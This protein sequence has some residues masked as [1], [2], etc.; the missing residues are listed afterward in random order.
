MNSRME[1]HPV[2]QGPQR[3]GDLA[4]DVSKAAVCQRVAKKGDAIGAGYYKP[5]MVWGA[6][7]YTGTDEVWKG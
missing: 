1:L 7:G 5:T 3:V 2:G 4:T 6:W